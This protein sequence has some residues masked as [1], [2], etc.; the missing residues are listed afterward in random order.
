MVVIKLFQ[1]AAKEAIMHDARIKP[2]TGFLMDL[3]YK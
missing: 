2:W 3:V 1:F